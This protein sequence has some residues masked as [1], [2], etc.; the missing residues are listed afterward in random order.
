MERTTDLFDPVL[1]ARLKF[2]M[3]D[4]ITFDPIIAIGGGGDSEFIYELQPQLEF[5]FT[6]LSLPE[7]ATG[8]C[9]TN[10]RTRQATSLTAPFTA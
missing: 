9:T 1:V 5:Q 2:P 6:E 4:W 3:N 10:T 8:V 7:S